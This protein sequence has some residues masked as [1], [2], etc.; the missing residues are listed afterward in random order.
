MEKELQGSGRAVVF[1][2]SGGIGAALVAELAA[3][4]WHVVA[5]SRQGVK[6]SGAATAFA[7]DLMD[8]GTIAAAASAMAA[9]PPD[10]VFVATGALTLPDGRGPEKSYR[11]IDSD[12]LAQAFA[13][14]AVGPALIAKH[15]LPLLPRDR[16]A[17][18]AALGARVGSI[19][20]NRLGGWHGYRASKAALAMLIRNFAIEMARTHPMAI[21]AGLHPG[22]VATGLSAPFRR[23]GSDPA[24]LAPRDAASHLLAVIDRLLPEDSGQV[25]DWHG[26]AVPP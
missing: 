3:R 10:L 17:V 2:A 1:G 19:G 9:E 23:Q 16:R 7:F 14:N 18:F 22:T 4:G 26:D 20:D 6:P 12:A 13:L 25:F 15:F 24:I 11:Q 21:V 5:G 8:E